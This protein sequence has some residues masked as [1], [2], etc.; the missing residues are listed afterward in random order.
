MSEETGTIFDTTKKLGSLYRYTFDEGLVELKTKI[1]MTTGM[2]FNDLFNTFYFTDA[3]DTKIMQYMYD[4]KT[5]TITGEKLLTD[6]TTYVTPK[7]VW[8]Y[9]MTTDTEGYLYIA[10]YGGTKILKINTT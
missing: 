1:G 5:G 4:L 10:L 8:T 9:G 2:T 6:L 3:Y 7:T